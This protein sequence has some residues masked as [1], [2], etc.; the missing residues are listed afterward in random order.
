MYRDIL[1]NLLEIELAIESSE[2]SGEGNQHLCERWMHVHEEAAF[3]VSTVSTRPKTKRVRDG[4][5][6]ANPPKWTSSKT[7]LVG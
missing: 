1:S 4:Y 6:V 5:F 2:P 3:D 7:T